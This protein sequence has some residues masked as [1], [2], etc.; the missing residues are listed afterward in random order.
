MNLLI[1]CL[2]VGIIG[3]ALGRISKLID[4]WMDTQIDKEEEENGS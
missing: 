4:I 3:F 2:G 1:V